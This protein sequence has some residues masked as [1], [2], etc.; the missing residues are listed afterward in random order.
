MTHDIAAIREFVLRQDLFIVLLLLTLLWVLV[1][2][3]SYDGQDAAMLLPAPSFAEA[4]DVFIRFLEVFTRKFYM[5]V[6]EVTVVEAEAFDV[7]FET[8]FASC[9]EDWC[10]SRLVTE[11]LVPFLVGLQFPGFFHGLIR[12]H[13]GVL[14]NLLWG[15]LQIQ[16]I[17]I[18]LLW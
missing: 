17:A 4:S 5:G 16:L 12:N 8:G 2:W 10:I 13:T 14:F 15:F 18:S 7:E 1:W 11:Q 3:Y 6:S 9:A